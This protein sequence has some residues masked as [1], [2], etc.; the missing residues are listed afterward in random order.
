[1]SQPTKLCKDCFWCNLNVSCTPYCFLRDLWVEHGD[2]C[3]E[4]KPET[5]EFFEALKIAK[6]NPKDL[7]IA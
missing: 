1:M 2:T 6:I 3:K 7:D 4:W 5:L